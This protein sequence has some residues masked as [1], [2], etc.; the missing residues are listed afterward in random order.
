MVMV[1]ARCSHGTGGC[2]GELVTV[3]A[4]GSAGGW[5]GAVAVLF[6]SPHRHG[7]AC[8]W[9]CLR[10]RHDA[11]WLWVCL[12]PVVAGCRLRSYYVVCF[13]SIPSVCWRVVCD[14]PWLVV[15]FCCFVS[16]FSASFSFCVSQL[17]PFCLWLQVS[18]LHL[19]VV[20][21][22]CL[23]TCSVLLFCALFLPCL[24]AKQCELVTCSASVR[25][26]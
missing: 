7:G 1:V 21:F 20:C 15:V 12:L 24:G 9:F 18:C 22:C 6:G 11:N 3:P 2:G 4:V 14:L 17:S 16:G 26:S 10:H 5:G 25:S 13:S 23:F 8:G 19:S